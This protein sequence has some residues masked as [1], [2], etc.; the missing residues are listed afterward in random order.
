MNPNQPLAVGLGEV[1]WDLLPAGKQLGGAPANF[2]Y[3]AQALGAKS[4]IVSAVGRD[5]RGVELRRQ[6][7]ALNLDLT[8]LCIEAKHPTGIVSVEVGAAGVPTYTI[9]EDVAWDYIRTSPQIDDLA[10]RTDVVCF[11]SLAQRA[12]IS[13]NTIRKFLT[14]MRPESLRIFDI[15]LRQNFYNETIVRESLAASNVLKLNDAEW[16]IVIQLLSLP[17]EEPAAIA[18]L[19]AQFKLKLIALTRGSAGS[20]LWWPDQPPSHHAGFTPAQL[21]DTVG[22]GDAFTAAVAMG[23]LKNRSLDQINE[24]ANRL[25]S[26]VC[27]QAGATPPIPASLVTEINGS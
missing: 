20:S 23:L 19:F 5:D 22:A 2:A 15:N 27:T 9:H 8:G 3:H 13:R 11:G 1:L 21:V 16:P 18:A 10:A 4:S 17:S 24:S 7:L 12:E 14:S 6:L 26:Y 25:A